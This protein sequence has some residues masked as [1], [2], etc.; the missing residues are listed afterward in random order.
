MTGENWSP[1]L[2]WEGY[3]EVSN[4]GRLRS[5]PREILVNRKTSQ[6][7]RNSSGR[8][9]T[10]YVDRDG[11]KTLHLSRDGKRVAVKVH[12][13]VAEA[14]IGP[15]P[16]GRPLVL[17]SDGDPGNNRVSNLRWGNQSE[18]LLDAIAH[19]THRSV[20]QT[21]CA[22]GHE[23]TPDNTLRGSNGSRRCRECHRLD[24]QRAREKSIE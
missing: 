14:F 20:T 9:L 5:V 11:Y 6:Y 4:E 19:G 10:P 17:H 7:V 18:N 8:I 12:R 15:E 23:Y 22:Q 13:L 1:V 2:D 3:Y 21:H 16:P 24:R